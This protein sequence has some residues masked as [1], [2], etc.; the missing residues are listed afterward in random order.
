MLLAGAALCAAYAYVAYRRL[1][2]PLLLGDAFDD[3]DEEDGRGG[4]REAKEGG[5]G[6]SGAARRGVSRGLLSNEAIDY[7][8]KEPGVGLYETVKAITG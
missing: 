7:Y 8:L 1:N 4:G 5:E 3:E 6:G 2:R